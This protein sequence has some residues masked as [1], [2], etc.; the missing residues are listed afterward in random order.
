MSYTSGER[1]YQLL[2]ALYRERDAEAGF[3]LRD[4]VEVL[5]REARIVEE[6][7]E[8]LYEGWFIETCAEWKV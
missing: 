7:I 1:L 3:P 4:F 8:D 6:N 5:A 2:P